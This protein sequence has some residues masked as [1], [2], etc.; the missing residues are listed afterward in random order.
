MT[1]LKKIF[2]WLVPSY[3]YVP[4]ILVVVFNCLAYYLTRWITWDAKHYDL[5]IFMDDLLPF[6]PWFISFYIL[7]YV[8]W[9]WNYIMHSRIDR[10]LCYRLVMANLISKVFC[11]VIFLCLPTAIVRPEVTGDGLWAWCV[12]FIYSADVPRT[13]FPS[14][15]CLESYMA[16]RG[17]TMFKNAPKWYAPMQL[18]FAVGVFL[19]TVFVKQHFVVDIIG[20]IVVAELGWIL[21]NRCGLWRLLEKAELPFVRRTHQGVTVDGG[22]G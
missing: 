6:T 13:L 5:S 1:R 2:H 18:L 14:I 21:S 12:R 10:I 19:S 7:A 22:E 17:A 4:L 16:F 11:F 3:A 8:Q 15:H 9:A 20:G